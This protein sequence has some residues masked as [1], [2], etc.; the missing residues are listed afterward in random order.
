MNNEKEME[1]IRDGPAGNFV[2]M[3]KK[4]YMRFYLV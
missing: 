3:N 4:S 2:E 1:K